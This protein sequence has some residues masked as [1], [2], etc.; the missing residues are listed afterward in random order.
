MVLGNGWSRCDSLDGG[1]AAP[2][3][4]GGRVGSWPL[5]EDTFAVPELFVADGFRLELLGPQHNEAD[6][7]AWMSSI[8]HI[9]AT[10][11]FDAGWPPAGGM[12][13]AENLS[14]LQQ[15]AD[16]SARRLD[17]AYSV[18]EPATGDVI[19]CVYFKPSRTAA[20]EVLASS[21]VRADR[22]DL[23]G[24]LTEVVGAWLLDAW[25]FPI[26]HYRESL[27]PTTIRKDLMPGTSGASAHPR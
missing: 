5:L 17:F 10:P 2:N 6:H 11:G 18:I 13:L 7:A 8:E 25:P 26:V 20:G 15:H 16:R 1:S 9:R 22:A 21:W 12:S 19:G 3:G 27:R 23:D 24:P 4:Y 14:D